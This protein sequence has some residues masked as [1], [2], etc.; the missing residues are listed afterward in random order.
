MISKGAKDSIV[1]SFPF[2]GRTDLDFF[3]AFAD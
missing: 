3:E 2:N 1:F